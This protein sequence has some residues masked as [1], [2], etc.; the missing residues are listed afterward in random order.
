MVLLFVL[1]GM[2]AVVILS[3]PP[4][5][6]LQGQIQLP[7]QGEWPDTQVIAAGSVVRGVVVGPDGHYHLRGLPTGKYSIRVQAPGYE[8]ATIQPSAQ[9]REGQ[10]LNL[11]P[12]ELRRLP[13]ALSMYGT[14]QVFTTQET[15]Q[16]NIRTSGLARL[17][18]QLD[19]LNLQDYL[20]TSD[21]R[22]LADPYG[23]RLPETQPP[24]SA[25]VRKWTQAL[26]APSEDGWIAMTLPIPGELPPGSYRLMA[27][28]TGLD[29]TPL[30]SSYW[31]TVTDLGWF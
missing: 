18:L 5:G 20:G 31:F 9:V 29:Q 6:S 8:T 16:V 19:P 15:P 10:S 7:T 1:L 17:D 22:D 11:D 27:T 2:G 14:S 12:V 21:L 26:P 24:L 23:Y 4:T 30:T 25:P 13:P 3:E 28:G